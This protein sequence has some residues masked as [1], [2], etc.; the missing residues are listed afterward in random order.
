MLSNGTIEPS[1]SEYNSPILLA[2]KK[3]LPN[4][5]ERR[6]RFCVDYRSINKKLLS[7]TFPLPR[8]DDILDQLGR[9]R[10]FSC[11]DFLNGFHQVPLEEDSKDITSFS[12]DKGSFRFNSI[13]FGLK[14]GPSSFQRMMTLAFTGLPPDQGFIYMDD[15][16]IV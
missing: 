13:P 15:L 6:W 14:I 16:I 5:P 7:D 3:S 1:R 4:N 12:T 9:A 2:P 8:V 11:I 10:L